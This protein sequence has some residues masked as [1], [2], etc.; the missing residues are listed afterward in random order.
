[1]ENILSFTKSPTI[2]AK[3]D[4]KV[5]LNVPINILLKDCACSGITAGKQ[6]AI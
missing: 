4:A 1:L 5:Q 3:N 6:D 2:K